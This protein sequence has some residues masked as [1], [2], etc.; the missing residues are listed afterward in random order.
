MSQGPTVRSTIPSDVALGLTR[1][2]L[3]PP[4]AG[5]EEQGQGFSCR[6]RTDLSISSEGTLLSRQQST[7]RFC[8]SPSFDEVPSEK[9]LQNEEQ[10]KHRPEARLE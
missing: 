9:V 4:R 7:G 3:Q 2:A 8:H 10:L 6:T 5:Y 1:S